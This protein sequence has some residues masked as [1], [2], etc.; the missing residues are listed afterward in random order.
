MRLPVRVAE[1]LR[2]RGMGIYLRWFISAIKLGYI[3]V[4]DRNPENDLVPMVPREA[5]KQ[6]LH[7]CL[8]QADMQ[9]PIRQL[10]PKARREGISTIIQALGVFLCANIPRFRALTV[11]HTDEAAKE[12]FSLAKLIVD[13]MPDAQVASVSAKEITFSNG[14][15]YA[16]TTAGGK[17]V[18]RG[19]T[20][21]FLHL[22]EVASYQSVS[23]MDT[24]ALNALLNTVALSSSTFVFM[25]ST[26]E[27][28]SGQFYKRCMSAM[29]NGG[30]GKD[31]YRLCFLPWFIDDEYVA[32]PIPNETF[33]TYEQTLKHEFKLRDDQLW[34]YSRKR[35]EAVSGG[36]QEFYFRREFPSRLMEC[37][38]GASGL[39]YQSFS[40]K[41]IAQIAH[42]PHEGGITYYRSV[43]WGETIDPFVILWLWHNPKGK[44]LLTVDPSCKDLIRELQT[45]AY[46]DKKDYP[47]DEDN[48]GPDAIRM[49]VVT[50]GLSGHVHVYRS[51]Y[52]ENAASRG[53]D[54]C[55]RSMHL[56]SGWRLPGMDEHGSGRSDEMDLKKFQPDPIVGEMYDSTVADR[57]R[58]MLI[59]M[60]TRYGIPMIPHTKPHSLDKTKG[61]IL[62]GIA[63]V[64]RLVIGASYL[65]APKENRMKS[66]LERALASVNG[67]RPRRLTGEEQE[68]LD[69]YLRTVSDPNTPASDYSWMYN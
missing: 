38:T 59:S 23:G 24:R 18:K 35:N 5:Q 25:E 67:P 53:L 30:T 47:R 6:L 14:S 58:P 48:H 21:H 33:N 56:L 55:A 32:E 11:A 61:E 31:G 36:N 50:Y 17:G 40:E 42:P 19:A 60:M 3:V 63:L 52:I 9:Q 13:N 45:Y 39:V 54:G 51:L 15:V 8:S 65:D 62:D 22:S 41:N 34:F 57:S 7:S 12:I 64:N 1:A 46:D 37:F 29:E 43:D 69:T 44:P 27:G 20:V 10:V 68:A 66:A 28:P 4:Q 26:G 2:N 16:C 49:A